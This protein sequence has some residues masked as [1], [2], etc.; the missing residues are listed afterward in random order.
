MTGF[1]MASPSSEPRTVSLVCVVIG[2]LT[3]YNIPAPAIR[4][5]QRR[6]HEQ[7]YDPG[8]V[9]GALGPETEEGLDQMLSERASDLKAKYREDVVSGSR[10]R[11]LTAYIQL[12]ARD[13]G[14][15]VGPVDGLWGPQTDY[16]F[17]ALQHLD[18]YDQPPPQWRDPQEIPN[19]NNWPVKT[20]G[21]LTDAYG[22]PGGSFSAPKPP[23]TSLDL[24]YQHRLSWDQRKI[25]TQVLCHER[26]ADSLH[27]VLTNVK[28]HYGEK[29]IRELRLHLF[30]GCFNPRRKRGGSGWSTHAWGIAL[31]Y[32][33]EHNRLKWGRDRAAF[34][35][36]EYRAWWGFWEEEGWVSLGRTKNYDWMHVQAARLP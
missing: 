20:E 21:V 19:P 15:E 13:A 11:K 36:P 18:E 35:K 34:A 5:A 25:K 28:E 1:K 12:L 24:P 26:V 7:G 16:A 8:S 14:V 10:K 30:G 32:D 9:D 33:P 2:P 22:P 4:L 27:R 6:L 23:L 31:D 3:M 17:D 29:R